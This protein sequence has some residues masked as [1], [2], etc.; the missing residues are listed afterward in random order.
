[1]K[2]SKESFQ[3]KNPDTH[4]HR[5]GEEQW[6]GE[7]RRVLRGA[8]SSALWILGGN[9]SLELYLEEKWLKKGFSLLQVLEGQE[10]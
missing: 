1:M 5:R 10:R 3:E 6:S 2:E 7:A 9:G 8:V 4:R